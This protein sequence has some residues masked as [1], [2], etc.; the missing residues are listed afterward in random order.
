[1]DKMDDFR[2]K[3]EVVQKEEGA[4]G[5]KIL[6]PG[7]PKG[8]EICEYGEEPGERVVAFPGKLW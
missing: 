7:A 8:P 2:D 4:A 1:M 5:G 6:T 3:W